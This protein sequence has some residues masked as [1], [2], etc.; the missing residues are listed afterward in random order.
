MNISPKHLKASDIPIAPESPHT[1]PFT[2]LYAA[3]A[4]NLAEP[5]E[6]YRRE[7]FPYTNFEWIIE[8]EGSLEIDDIPHQLGAGDLF[9]LPRGKAHHYFPK[10]KRPWRKMHVTLGGPLVQTLMRAYQLEDFVSCHL[11][12]ARQH[13]HEWIE[14]KASPL[15]LKHQKASIVFQNL[16]LDIQKQQGHLE[17][18]LSQDVQ[19]LKE[20]LDASIEEK[21][22]IKDLCLDLKLN[23]RVVCRKFKQQLGLSPYDHLL[24]LRYELALF[25]LPN[26]EL[27][28]S[29][30]AYRLQ[31]SDV[32]TFSKFF[33]QRH[34]M[35]PREYVKTQ[36]N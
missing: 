5:H 27:N 17:Q 10:S 4:E 18:A 11:P 13:F 7:S 8:G 36:V 23:Q 24:N 29:E 3:E 32:Y 21:V 31:F 9:S 16:L 15:Q 12:K 30:V 20:H 6:Q 25:L 1:F 26:S 35:S 33:K 22:F 19:T 2:L 28:I 34:G 14:L